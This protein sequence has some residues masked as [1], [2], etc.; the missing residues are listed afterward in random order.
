MERA[1]KDCMMTIET[2][3]PLSWRSQSAPPDDPFADQSPERQRLYPG[4]SDAD[5]NSSTDNDS[6]AT[7]ETSSTILSLT[8]LRAPLFFSGVR[9]P[10]PPLILTSLPFYK[11]LGLIY[12]AEVPTLLG[13]TG[14]IAGLYATFRSYTQFFDLRLH[15]Y[16]NYLA[17]SIDVLALIQGAASYFVRRDKST[18][19]YV[20]WHNRNKHLDY[21]TNKE[22]SSAITPLISSS[23]MDGTRKISQ[24]AYKVTN[25]GMMTFE[26][27]LNCGGFFTMFN[28]LIVRFAGNASLGTVIPSGILTIATVPAAII[29]LIC[30]LHD[31]QKNLKTQIV[32]TIDLEDPEE[33]IQI[34]ALEEIPLRI[35]ILSS[36]VMALVIAGGS[37]S[38]FITM[39]QIYLHDIGALLHQNV[40]YRNIML[41]LIGAGL[42]CT[43]HV[44]WVN[45]LE[46]V[47]TYLNT[48]W[49][50]NKP[51][52]PGFN[53]LTH[54]IPQ[55]R[56]KIKPGTLYVD[57][58]EN[59]TRYYGI[60]P[61][62]MVYEGHVP[63]TKGDVEISVSTLKQMRKGLLT[64]IAENNGAY[65]NYQPPRKISWGQEIY[66]SG[67]M[68]GN[69]TI[70]IFNM[71]KSALNIF[72]SVY[73]ISGSI[74]LA[75]TAAFLVAFSTFI[76][77][78][79]S[80]MVMPDKRE[81]SKKPS[82]VYAGVGYDPE[83]DKLAIR[84][85]IAEPI[86][87]YTR[88]NT[89]GGGSYGSIQ[90]ESSLFSTRHDATNA[91]ASYALNASNHGHASSAAALY[92]GSPPRAASSL[93]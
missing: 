25:P 51:I 18:Q 15:S 86:G 83:S 92:D 90:S 56:N 46:R 47:E 93:N 39:K 55:D 67:L 38:D 14:S 20:V 32:E 70:G 60:S 24:Y 9:T 7:Q 49:I 4:D 12:G 50:G 23:C 57:F 35:K 42:V 27:F 37:N 6:D 22:S 65:L 30:F 89:L 87:E 76:Y 69:N 2:P 5:D 81:L 8:D 21:Q 10:T 66:E 44:K 29:G 34:S 72:L 26:V 19:R 62:E 1:D 45:G 68:V 43:A 59:E 63:Y 28:G 17:Y 91:T 48:T 52:L 74:S 11:R 77:I 85:P 36:S 80:L 84:S 54:S 82:H 58:S 53:F 79:A 88:L 73:L 13:T 3:S 71:L 61:E 78:K 31:T 40:W 16:Y 75:A 64:I 33:I 41:G